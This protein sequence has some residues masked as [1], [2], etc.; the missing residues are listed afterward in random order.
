MIRTGTI[1]ALRT[2]HPP[3]EMCS[4]A[5]KTM[6]YHK[7][8]SNQMS[9]SSPDCIIHVYLRLEYFRNGNL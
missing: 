7:S 2:R 5:V 3:Y 1:T 8:M 9:N 6:G 4:T